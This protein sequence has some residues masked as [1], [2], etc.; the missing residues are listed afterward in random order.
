MSCECF[1][2][3]VRLVGLGSLCGR[4]RCGDK[5][6]FEVVVDA[7]WDERGQHNMK[8]GASYKI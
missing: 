6:P 2:N 3:T 1:Q 5:R 7:Q 8:W 4:A